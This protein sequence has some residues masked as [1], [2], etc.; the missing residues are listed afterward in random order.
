M[1]RIKS[2]TEQAGYLRAKAINS[3]VIQAGESFVAHM[4]AY[5]SSTI[6]VP[7][8][9]TVQSAKTVEKIKE[10]S[11]EKLYNQYEVLLKEIAGFKVLSGL[12]EIYLDATMNPGC[13]RAKKILQILPDDITKEFDED[14]YLTLM[15]ITAYV[16]GMTDKF[17]V[18]R[19][20]ML[21][22]IEIPDY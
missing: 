5:S 9:K 11:R 18:D 3:L 16:C 17:A 6:I 15:D 19:Y 14:P 2:E 20:R 8:I 12:L 22:G 13:K 1:K 21:T 10:L 7:L 4:K